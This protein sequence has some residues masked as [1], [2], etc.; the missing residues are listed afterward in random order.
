[1]TASG[2]RELKTPHELIRSVVELCADCDREREVAMAL[3][4]AV[5]PTISLASH[6]H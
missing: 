4:C 6:N 3:T 2:P 1:M 5:N